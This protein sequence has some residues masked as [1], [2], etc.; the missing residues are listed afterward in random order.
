MTETY[1]CLRKLENEVIFELTGGQIGLGDENFS[2][3]KVSIGQFYGIEINDFAVTVAKTALWIAESQMMK[4]TE[5]I[6]HMDLDF[7]PLKSYANIVEAN[8][9]RINWEDVVPKDKLNYIMGNPPFVGKKEQTVPH[10][11]PYLIEAPDIWL[12]TRNT[13]ITGY[14]Q[15]LYGSM[16]INNGYLIISEKE[17]LEI[18]KKK[19]L[20]LKIYTQICM[21]RRNIKM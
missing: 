13:Q 14:N 20:I 8:A 6:L 15:I 16:P 12:K 10:I 5:N 2:P 21:S 18:I 7:L 19:N 4:D 17:Y 1:L 3:I 11:N 9:L